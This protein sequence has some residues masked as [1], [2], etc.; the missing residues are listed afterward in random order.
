VTNNQV[1]I[2]Q[3]IREFIDNIKAFNSVRKVSIVESIPTEKKVEIKRKI[4]DDISA[5]KAYEG[6]FRFFKDLINNK[7]KEE[8]ILLIHYVTDQA[9][10]KLY[11]G[12]QENKEIEK[13][14]IWED[15]NGINHKLSTNYESALRRLEMKKLVKV[16]ALTGSGNP[17]EMQITDEFQNE[18]LNLS[19]EIIEKINETIENNPK[20]DSEQPVFDF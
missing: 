15:I 8:E 13:I 3:K 4:K 12:W 2:S 17:K 7:L 11:T 14:K 18:L 5:P 19:D 20:E 16:I 6:E 9:K 10:F 1:L